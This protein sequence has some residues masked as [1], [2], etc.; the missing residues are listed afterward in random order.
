[1]STELELPAWPEGAAAAVAITFDVD[2]EA[3]W[4]A[5]GKEYE[6]RLTTLSEARFGI[7]RGLPRILELL[8]A[9]SVPATFYV[10]GE[11]AERHEAALLGLLNDG[12]EVGHHGHRHLRSDK[13]SAE[14][15]REEIELGLEALDRVFG[16]RP[17]GYRSASWEITPETFA[18]LGEFEF[19]YD[20]SFMGDDRPYIER[21]DGFEILEL[22][23]HWSLDDWPYFAWTIEAGGNL[24]SPA[25]VL[26]IW[27]RE[28][29]SAIADGRLLT[30]TMHPEVI[31]RGYRIGVLEKLIQ[32]AR[33]RGNVWFATHGQVAD[34]VLGG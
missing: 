9:E 34:H 21:L 23:V 15:Q 8:A 2:A 6:R 24:A 17:R 29:D 4:L 11:T 18:L 16:I 5:E 14:L 22:P 32:L 27:T 30:L 1:M 28:L 26:D 12:H 3:G 25:R 33:Q 20:S 19:A 10:P 31:G 7:T 13:A